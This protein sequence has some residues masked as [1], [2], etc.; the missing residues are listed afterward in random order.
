[1]KKVAAVFRPDRLQNVQAELEGRG[2][3]GFTISD[4]RGHGQSP[5]TKGE[6]RGQSYELAVAHKL[7]IEII[8]DDHEVSD[9][10][11]AI[12][13]GARTGKMGDGLITVTDILQVFQIR[14]FP[15]LAIDP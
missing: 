1:M 6:W 12:T 10:V 3:A 8:V 7:H 5:E 13:T 4:V 9:V 11:E 2:F 15:A 14:D